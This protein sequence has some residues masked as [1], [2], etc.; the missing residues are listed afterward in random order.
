[1]WFFYGIGYNIVKHSRDSGDTGSRNYP[2]FLVFKFSLC[3]ANDSGGFDKSEPKIRKQS[4]A[5]P[6]S[7]WLRLQSIPDPKAVFEFLATIPLNC[8][9]KFVYACIG[10]H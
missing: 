4:P 2:A 1:M 7:Q 9:Y 8:D 6:D 3:A 5:P 10:K